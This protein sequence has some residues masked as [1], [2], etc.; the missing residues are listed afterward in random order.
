MSSIQFTI[1]RRVADAIDFLALR[2]EATDAQLERTSIE[3]SDR[4]VTPRGY[5]R[6]TCSIP[7]G[8][9]FIERLRVLAGTVAEDDG[10]LLIQCAAA[11]KNATDAIQAQHAFDASS[12]DW[13]KRI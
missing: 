1:P 8:R 4:D 10:E 13:Q 7:M 6:I 5:T 2:R 12:A 9:L 3:R 11:V